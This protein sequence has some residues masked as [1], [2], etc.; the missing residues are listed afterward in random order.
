M[1]TT[2]NRFDLN[3]AHQATF[4]V[5]DAAGVQI[6]CHR[7]CLWITLDGDQRD[8]VLEAGE[9]FVATEHRRALIYALAPSSLSLSEASAAPARTAARAGTV[10]GGKVTRALQPA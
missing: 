5:T 7:G 6:T 9:R 3:L 2:S 10:W 1:N 4:Q 8:I